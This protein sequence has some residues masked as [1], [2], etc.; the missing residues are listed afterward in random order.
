[1]THSLASSRRRFLKTSLLGGFAFAAGRF[2]PATRAAG[3]S[4]SGETPARVALTTGTDRAAMTFNG[5][6]PFAG[7]LKRAIGSRR[8]VIK[9][10][11]VAIDTPLCGSVLPAREYERSSV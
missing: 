9:P 1:M 11:N 4:A 7:E 2:V 10:N 5:L 3:E 8:V 6:K